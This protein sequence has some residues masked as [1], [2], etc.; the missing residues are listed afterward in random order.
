LKQNHALLFTDCST[1]LFTEI[2]TYLLAGNMCLVKEQ[3]FHNE[4][5]DEFIELVNE[6]KSKII[7]DLENFFLL[8]NYTFNPLTRNFQDTDSAL[9]QEIANEVNIRFENFNLE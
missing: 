2:G 5:T 4:N 8:P 3:Y 9:R 1:K 7:W 6:T